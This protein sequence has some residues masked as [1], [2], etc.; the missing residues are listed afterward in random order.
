MTHFHQGI[1][2]IN[3]YQ[4]KECRSEVMKV[5]ILSYNFQGPFDPNKGFNNDFAAVYV[6]LDSNTTVID[7]GE[8]GNINGRFPNHERTSCWLIHS[9]GKI[10]LYIYLE[11]SE[12]NRRVIESAIRNAYN[13][14]CGFK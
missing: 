4:I 6:I 8:T 10:N 9:N 5:Q 12:D 14:P 7:V 1:G 11:S 13:P 2:D 3:S